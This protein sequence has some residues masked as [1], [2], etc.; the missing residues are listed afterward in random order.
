VDEFYERTAAARAKNIQS[1]TQGI[2]LPVGES[3]RFSKA[4]SSR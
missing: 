4:S 2:D 3:L 1:E